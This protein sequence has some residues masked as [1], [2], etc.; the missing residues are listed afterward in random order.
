MR[1]L[2]IRH[3]QT[4]HN[5][6]GALDTAFPGAGLTALGA[7][8]ALAVPGAL[9]DEDITAIYAS[10]LIRTQL[11][12][13]PLAEARRLEVRVRD[14][15]EEV[16]AG[17]LELR[18]DDEARHAY[19]GCVAGWMCGD[20]DRGMPGGPTGRDF[21]LRFDAALRA[22]AKDHDADDTIA[23]FS[24]GAAIRAYV[25]LAADLDPQAAT[26]LTILNTGL[27]LLVGHPDSGWDLARWSSDPLGGLELRDL[28]ADDITGES[29][30]EAT[31]ER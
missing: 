12:A 27:G 31:G 6:S 15:L 29:A 13:A 4:P 9:L 3:G 5:V 7:A 1:V 14:G 24:H 8:Q 16:S 23:V 28:R 17:E 2:L 18:S 26:G 19:A 30:R 21:F 20:L 25:A 22:I 11:T 10:R